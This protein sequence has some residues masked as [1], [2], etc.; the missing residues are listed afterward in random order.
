[1][2][3]LIDSKKN[4]IL[5]VFFL[6]VLTFNNATAQDDMLCVGRYWTEDEGNKMLKEFQKQWNDK[7]SWEK[8]A[9]MIRQGII[10]GLKIEQM[11]KVGN[12]F[13][14]II[15]QNY[16]YGRLYHPEYCY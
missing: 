7:D 2:K 10:D 13:N 9:D 3:R 11:P 12:K 15:T 14:P 5:L 16:A 1:M 6:F 8:R 4:V